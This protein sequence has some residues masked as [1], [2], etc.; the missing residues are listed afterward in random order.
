MPNGLR[1]T[2][3]RSTSVMTGVTGKISRAASR[4]ASSQKVFSAS[5]LKPHSKAL[6]QGS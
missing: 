4:R 6:H 1:D 2:L 3:M 5:S